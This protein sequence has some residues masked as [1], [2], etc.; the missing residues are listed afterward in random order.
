[1]KNPVPLRPDYSAAAARDAGVVLNTISR[2][3]TYL[4]RGSMTALEEARQQRP[5]DHNLHEVIEKG[6]VTPTSSTGVTTFNQ[7]AVRDIAAIIPLSAFAAIANR[8]IGLTL[9]TPNAAQSVPGLIASA[10]DVAFVAQS[11]PIPVAQLSFDNVTLSEHKVAT[12][13]T[14][15][16]ELM[17]ST[18]AEAILK[19]VLSE[20]VSLG[21]DAK[22]LDATE[23]DG[24]RPSGLRFNVAAATSGGA[25]KMADDLAMIA[26][27]VS[28]KAGSLSNII[29]VCSPDV[30]IRIA[31]LYPMFSFPV[32]ATAGLAAKTILALA[33]NALAIAASP[34]IEI[35]VSDETVVHM[36]TAPSA[37]STIG[38]P[39][40]IVAAPLRSMFSTDCSAIRLRF[41]VDWKLRTTNAIS[42]LENVAWA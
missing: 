21:V 18:N 25:T 40:N 17:N 3:A 11:A 36:D 20:S 30:A 9:D 41:S 16:R 24:I 10:N 5:R 4:A 23:T 1:M 34:T 19:Q 29:F 37:F 12:I 6:A 33:T 15:T 38:T 26:S 31:I 42:W 22:L 2:A 7:S 39:N 28:A 13:T 14:L 32:V 35:K 8:S 27:N